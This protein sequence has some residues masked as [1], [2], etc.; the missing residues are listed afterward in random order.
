MELKMQLVI[1]K[2]NRIDIMDAIRGVAILSMVFYHTLYDI[3]DIFGYPIPILN[4]LFFEI[5]RQPF[6]WAFILLAGVSSRFSHSNL[7]RGAR[8]FAFGMIVTV[9]TLVFIP[10][11]S[12]YFG[13]L[14]FMGCAILLFELVRVP[15]DKIPRKFALVLW[16][17]LFAVTFVMP[18]R[19]VIGFPGLFCIRLPDFLLNTPN[20][21]PLGFPDSNFYSADY[22]PMIPW[23]FMFLIGTVV[24]VPI[25]EHKLPEKFYTARVPFL[26]AAGRNTLLIYV[27]H[28]PIV[29]GLLYIIFKII[30]L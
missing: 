8:V 13:I 2:N 3:S 18:D 4:T 1:H 16:S 6:T 24:G 23:F 25:R 22:F 9:V 20:I 17:L 28:Q 29:Y 26:A 19:G 21:Y 15:L 12:I 27:L 11:Q 10:S 7:K 14:H 30:H 5:V